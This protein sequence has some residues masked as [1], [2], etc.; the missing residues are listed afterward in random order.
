MT[1]LSR[2]L[3]TGLF[4]VLSIPGMTTWQTYNPGLIKF[5]PLVYPGNPKKKII[6]RKLVDPYQR[7]FAVLTT[8]TAWSPQLGER[9]LSC[10]W[11]EV[12][13]LI[14]F[15]IPQFKANGLLSTGILRWKRN[16]LQIL[17]YITIY[18]LRG[19]AIAIG[20]SWIQSRR[21]IWGKLHWLR[22]M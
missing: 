6:H 20:S 9:K 19:Y 2:T 13:S 10:V 12:T 17:L 7:L 3:T 22:T 18:M 15:I 5:K 4:R 14:Y 21:M 11:M 8:N 1:L 16:M